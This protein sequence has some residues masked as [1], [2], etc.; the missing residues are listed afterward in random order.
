MSTVVFM[1]VL[2]CCVMSTLP[3][4][5]AQ[6]MRSGISW[7]EPCSLGD[8]ELWF[9]MYS[10]KIWC[11]IFTWD[12]MQ[13]NGSLIQLQKGQTPLL[14]VIRK[15]N[16]ILARNVLEAGANPNH[17]KEVNWHVTYP[18]T[19]QACTALW[20]SVI[21]V[22]WSLCVLQGRPSALMLSCESG[23]CEMTELLLKS[24]ADPDVQQPVSHAYRVTWTWV[25]VRNMIT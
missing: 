14:I 15:G 23:N 2:A 25:H 13:I 6:L 16:A 17:M 12:I 18:D 3:V 20:W 22:M 11:I 4:T 9:S 1:H 19:P 21:C 10:C 8:S 5:P 24:Q 7:N